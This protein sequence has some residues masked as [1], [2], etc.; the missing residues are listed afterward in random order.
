MVD[1]YFAYIVQFISTR[2][3]LSDMTIVEKK[4]IVVKAADY[5]LIAGNLYKLGVDGI[6]R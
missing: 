4:K 5:E 3:A 1:D 6:F 2:K